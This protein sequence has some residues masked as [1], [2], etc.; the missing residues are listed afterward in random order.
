MT[1]QQLTS[2]TA[3]HATGMESTQDASMS[4]E[5]RTRRFGI[6]CVG[7]YGDGVVFK[8]GTWKPGGEYIQKLTV[9]TNRRRIEHT[10]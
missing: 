8:A 4:P 6:E 10:E 5:E 9:S 1:W 3:T 2:D 7:L